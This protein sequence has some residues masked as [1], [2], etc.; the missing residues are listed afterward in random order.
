MEQGI[1]NTFLTLLGL[2][3]LS[4]NSDQQKN[5]K[6]FT[7]P[8]NEQSY[9]VWFQWFERMLK[10]NNTLL[11]INKKNFWTVLFSL[12]PIGPVVSEKKIQ[13]KHTRFDTFGPLISFVYFR[14]LMNISTK[15]GS[16]WPSGFGERDDNL[17]AYGQRRWQ[18]PSDDNTSHDPLGQVS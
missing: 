10:T 18:M 7:E 6:L 13:N 4:S 16:N 8:F 15:F 17:N 12:V 3:L 1:I 5:H 2:L 11:L 9:Q 14:S